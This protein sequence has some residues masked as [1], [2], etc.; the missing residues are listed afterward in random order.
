MLSEWTDDNLI[1]MQNR[2][3]SWLRFNERV[4]EEAADASVPLL[5]RLKYIS[6][7]TSN[8]DEFFMI[9]VGSLQDISSVDPNFRDSKSGLS[10]KAQLESIYAT[11]RPLYHKKDKL[12]EQVMG[13]LKK[14]NVVSA[15]WDE[16]V[17][18]DKKFIRDYYKSVIRPILSPQVVDAHRPFPHIN[19]KELYIFAL[20]K[21]KTGGQLGILPVPTS[22]PEYIQLPGQTGQFILTEKVILEFTEELFGKL[23]VVEKNCIC[24][25]RNGDIT[26]DDESFEVTED[27]R[28]HVKKLLK[29]RNKMAAVRLEANF[30]LSEQLSHELCHHLKI[31]KEQIY[32]TSAPLKMAYVMD[33]IPRLK[34]EQFKGLVFPAYSSPSVVQ[35][36][37]ARSIIQQVRNKDLMVFHPYESIG[38]FLQLIKEASQNDNVISIKITIYRLAKKAKLVDYLCA[39]AENGK[40]V[41]VVV[42]LRARFDE[43]NNIDWSEKLE[44]SGCKVIY[45]FEDYKMH[46][47]VCLITYKEKNGINYI[48]QIGTGNYNEKTS[49]LYTDLSLMTANVS[50]GKDADEFFKNMCLGNLNG[51]YSNFLVA[52]NYFKHKILDMMDQEILKGRQGLIVLKLNALTDLDIIKKLSEASNSGVE[53][54]LIVRGICCLLPGIQGKTENVRV[55]SIVGRYL[56]HSR[57]YSFGRGDDQKLYITSADLMTRNME[58]RIEVACPIMDSEIKEKINHILEVYFYDNVKARILTSDGSYEKIVNNRIDINAQTYFCDEYACHRLWQSIPKTSKKPYW[59]RLLDYFKRT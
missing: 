16:L 37:R 42:E 59:E 50:I 28:S 39:A 9:R 41:T 22:L 56:E 12:Y 34:E 3:L 51:E 58:R 14:E 7:F 23:G 45:G 27:Y 24:I 38:I 35:I 53:V 5:E 30:T 57:I 47:K 32:I 6:I 25:T 18:T 40:D 48:T 13:L 43:Q 36:D 52:P 26:A 46:S 10:A 19:N 49:E 11:V 2:E 29:K 4:L 55:T 33:L 1:F 44:D 54:K 17:E 15:Q 8:L 20:L 21:N 31:K